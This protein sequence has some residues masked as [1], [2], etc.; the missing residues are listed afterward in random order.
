MFSGVV[1]DSSMPP[2]DPHFHLDDGALASLASQLPGAPV[3]I[4]HEEK[5]IGTINMARLEG[6]RLAVGWELDQTAAGMSMERLIEKGEAPELSLKHAKYGD[7]S[8]QPIEVSIVRKGA[9][10]GCA[11]DTERYKLAARNP[12]N[13]A[14]EDMTPVQT[15]AP[16][17][18]PMVAAEPAA[19]RARY[20]SPM[21]FL[22]TVSTKTNDTEAVELVADYLADMMENEVNT[23]QEIAALR[24]AKQILEEAQKNNVES[25]KNVVRDI[26]DT[27]GSLYQNFASGQMIDEAQKSK[28]STVLTENVDVREA[29]RPLLVAASAIHQRTALAA[30]AASHVTVNAAMTRIETLQKQLSAARGMN[31]VPVAPQWT[32]VAVPPAPPVAEVAASGAHANEQFKFK[33]PDI[34]RNAPSFSDAG[35]GRITRDSFVRKV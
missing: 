14:T 5:N 29:M 26:V 10:K 21:D 4:E 30:S 25:S 18:A 23:Q 9:R 19:K 7:G 35:V 22:K 13:M 33:V 32:P 6:G 11:I 16:A 34:L 20:D 15:E 17:A 8:V 1:Y 31:S 24:Q 12:S 28:L 2:S 3:R 27:L